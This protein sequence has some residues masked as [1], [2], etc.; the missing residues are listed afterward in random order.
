MFSTTEILFSSTLWLFLLCEAAVSLFNPLINRNRSKPRAA[1]TVISAHI[2]QD[3]GSASA[4]N[5]DPRVNIIKTA[6][7]NSHVDFALFL[8]LL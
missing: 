5:S 8:F 2:D 4:T 1:F 7:D 6:E 3:G